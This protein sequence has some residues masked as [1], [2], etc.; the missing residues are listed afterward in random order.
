VWRLRGAGIETSLFDADLMPAIEELNR[1][2]IREHP[3]IGRR[4]RSKSQTTEP[5]R[6]GEV[7]PNGHRIGYTD[8][9]DKVEGIPDEEAPGEEWPLV[10]RLNDE[11]IVRTYNEFWDKVWW[12][13]H[14]LWLQKDRERRGTADRRTEATPRASHPRRQTDRKEIR[15]E[16]PRLG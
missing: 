2:F 13:R 7:G 14:Q 1:D 12:N 10:L 9:G 15:K 11:A 8:E 6:P 4:R 3:T 16:E 5:V